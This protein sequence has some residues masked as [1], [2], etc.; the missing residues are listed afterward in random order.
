M[1]QEE[2]SATFSEAKFHGASKVRR[3]PAAVLPGRSAGWKQQQQP[4]ARLRKNTLGY[5]NRLKPEESE[6][7]KWMFN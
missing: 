6:V 2:G 5:S 4:G 3:L 1:G 7:W